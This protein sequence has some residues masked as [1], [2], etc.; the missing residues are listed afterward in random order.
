[1]SR[2]SKP[3]VVDWKP[4]QRG[5]LEVA[6]SEGLGVVAYDC[7]RLELLS[8]C[9]VEGSYG[10]K[11]VVLKQQ[12]IRL[13]D[14]DEIKTNLP[15]SGAALV[16]KLDAELERGATLD[17][18][19]A[20]IGNLTSTRVAVGRADLVGQC[21]GATHFVRG[22]NIGAFVM[23]AGN[24]ANIA[25]SM[26]LFGAGAGAGSSSSRVSRVE[27]GQ[28]EA[29]QASDLGPNTPPR[30]CS[31]LIRVHLVPIAAAAEVTTRVETAAVDVACPAG[32]VLS[33]GKCT[34]PSAGVTHQCQRGDAK[35]CSAQCE[36][37]DRASCHELGRLHLDGAGG[38]TRDVARART[39]LEKACGFDDGGGCSDLG[40]A[41]LSGDAASNDAAR[42]AASFDKG[43]KLGEAN[44]CFNLANL[45]YDGTGMPADKAK[46]FTL[47][48][49]A[50]NAGKAAGC[51][52]LGAAYDDGEGVAIDKSKALAL[53]KRACEGDEAIGC[54]NLAYMH[55]MGS[56]TTADQALAARFY[57]RGCT[58]G[59]AKS[60]EYAGLRYLDGRGVEKNAEKG[61]TLLKQACDGGL[62]TSCALLPSSAQAAVPAAATAVAPGSAPATP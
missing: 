45:Y 12:M 46:A 40:I 9:R 57:E 29:C 5:D 23:Q 44:G 13:T 17:L 2:G 54:S 41:L 20:L 24:S 21:E 26:S 19:T 28:L 3:L 30:N 1:M 22:A 53:F 56:G 55:S 33:E 7:Q 42:A 36:Q 47:Y 27:D 58:L 49:Q 61:R 15:L 59:N 16:A 34:K 51:I 14:A 48:E 4:E 52:N 25:T 37:G 8:D 60:C 62:Q 31:A 32:T 38:L 43:C 10:F 50:C 11:G 6:M 35:D 18:A 39:V